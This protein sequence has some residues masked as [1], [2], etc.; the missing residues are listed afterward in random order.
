MGLMEPIERIEG[1]KE[2]REK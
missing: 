2:I 1:F